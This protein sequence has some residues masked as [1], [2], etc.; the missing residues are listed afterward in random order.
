MDLTRD[1]ARYNELVKDKY[2]LDAKGFNWVVAEVLDTPEYD[3]DILYYEIPSFETKSGHA[4]I[5]ELWN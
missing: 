1:L 4:E 5:Y 2:K 3:A